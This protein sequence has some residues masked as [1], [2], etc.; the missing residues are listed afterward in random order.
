MRI[1]IFVAALLVM[2]AANSATV[3]DFDGP[4]TPPIRNESFTIG[5]MSFRSQSGYLSYYSY[6]TGNNGL[7]VDDGQY[8]NASVA[9]WTGYQESFDFVSFVTR[10]T[11]EFFISGQVLTESGAPVAVGSVTL[12]D[13]VSEDLGNNLTRYYLNDIFDSV[14]RV[15]FGAP[16]TADNF[17]LDDITYSAAVVPLPPAALL[18]SS[19]LAGLGWLRR[20]QAA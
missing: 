9:M 18:L 6:S 8:S 20:K 1:F 4:D 19:G 7:W 3:I 2:T 13:L 11:D 10:S 17:F 15:Y 12:G 5:D 16:S 14:E